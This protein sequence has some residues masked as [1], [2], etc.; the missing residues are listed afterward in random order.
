MTT[1][2]VFLSH[3]Y[4]SDK[5][6][7][8]LI[9]ALLWEAFVEGKWGTLETPQ[10]AEDQMV[11]TAAFKEAVDAW[12]ERKRWGKVDPR[13]VVRAHFIA[14]WRYLHELDLD[15]AEFYA[16]CNDIPNEVLALK[17]VCDPNEDSPFN[18]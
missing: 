14:A 16:L 2:H 4:N 15:D 5:K 6:A 11:L 13:Q 1:N 9:E 7:H 3:T 12:R 8:Q 10:A 18:H 17:Y